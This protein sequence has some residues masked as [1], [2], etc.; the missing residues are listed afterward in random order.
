MAASQAITGYNSTFE[1]ETAPG[2]GVF[3]FLAEV[4]DITPPNAKADQV[5]VTHM[6]SPGRAK[7]FV[8]GMTDYGDMTLKLNH[9]PSSATDDFISAWRADGTTR[10]TRI[11]Y[12]NAQTSVTPAF[13]LGYAP[14]NFNPGAALKATL[15]LKCAGVPVNS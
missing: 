11:T 5:E 7:E 2:S 6:Q 10:S 1:V 4:T 13:V 8:Q 3:T 12:P 14:D 9:I 15:T